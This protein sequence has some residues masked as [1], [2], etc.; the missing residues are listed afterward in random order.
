MKKEYRANFIEQLRLHSTHLN[1]F[2]III[3]IIIFFFFLKYVSL[4]NRIFVYIKNKSLQ[5]S[6]R[7]KIEG[8]TVTPPYNALQ[9]WKKK[10]KSVISA[11][12]S[13]AT[14][15]IEATTIITAKNFLKWYYGMFVDRFLCDEVDRE[16]FSLSLISNYNKRCRYL[17]IK[18]E[19]EF[20]G[21]WP[22]APEV[23]CH[24]L[25]RHFIMHCII[26][27]TRVILFLSFFLLFKKK[28]HRELP[29]S[30]DTRAFYAPGSIVVSSHQ[31][32]TGFF[33]NYLSIYS[34]LLIS[35]RRRSV[36]RFGMCI[37]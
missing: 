12:P 15:N 31:I 35:Y 10:K 7:G 23:D 27:N 28:Y 16:F 14:L 17:Q 30:E 32:F 36:R 26:I 25:P 21:I 29:F 5:R 19:K 33:A 9:I 6:L 11:P 22:Q 24:L 2:H 4:K 13:V 8:V 1:F 37:L 20:E 34:L 18:C 3:I